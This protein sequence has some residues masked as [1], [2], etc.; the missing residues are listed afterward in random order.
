MFGGAI[1]GDN[2]V[3]VQIASPV[4]CLGVICVHFRSTQCVLCVR[5]HLIDYL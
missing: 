5:L 2:C 4:E 1:A 3:C